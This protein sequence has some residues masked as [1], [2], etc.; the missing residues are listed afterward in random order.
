MLDA[1]R[2]LGFEDVEIYAA[3]L[4]GA[5][6]AAALDMSRIGPVLNEGAPGA[7]GLRQII[8]RVAAGEPWRLSIR[9]VRDGRRNFHTARIER[10][11][12]PAEPMTPEFAR[13]LDVSHLGRRVEAVTEFNLADI[14]A[15][16]PPLA[17][18]E[19]EG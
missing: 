4:Y 7:F 8:E 3:A 18:I 9:H 11:D 2:T 6:P 19:A 13:L 17:P 14:W 10:S 15:G 12:T 16:L 1:R 5:L